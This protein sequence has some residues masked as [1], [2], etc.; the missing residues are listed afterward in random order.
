MSTEG[1][2][3]CHY[4]P[5]TY[6]L[7]FMELVLGGTLSQPVVPSDS[8]EISPAFLGSW[9]PGGLGSAFKGQGRGRGD[10]HKEFS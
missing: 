10:G 6:C 2:E 1:A 7:V 8:T 3:R 5:V 4:V 9:Q